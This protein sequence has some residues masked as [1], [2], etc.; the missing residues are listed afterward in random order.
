MV[1]GTVAGWRESS[2]CQM[3]PY[4][5]Q[6]EQKPLRGGGRSRYSEQ[7][8]SAALYC[9]V[10]LH[11][12]HLAEQRCQ[13]YWWW[14]PTNFFLG[15]FKRGAVTGQQGLGRAFVLLCSDSYGCSGWWFSLCSCF[16]SLQ[17]FFPL[18]FYGAFSNMISQ[19]KALPLSLQR[20]SVWGFGDLIVTSRI[21]KSKET[22]AAVMLQTH[23]LI[24]LIPS[25][26]AN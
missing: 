6:R 13:Q 1:R 4:A 20:A 8:C 7:G 25:L 26:P 18:L 5:L 16:E 23:L 22:G 21:S 15:Y 17:S 24:F 2:A 12:L 9:W 3:L 14:N 11:L 10:T 19:C